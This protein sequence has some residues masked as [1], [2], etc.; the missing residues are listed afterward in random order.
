MGVP[1]AATAPQASAATAPLVR[2][3][4]WTLPSGDQTVQEYA[5]AVAIMQARPAHDPTSWT[6]Q[7]AMHGTHARSVQPLFNGCQHGTWFF[8][9]WHR[10]FIYYFEQI[11]RAAVV[12]AG[13]AAD[14]SLPFW[15][16]GAGGQQ[17]TLPAAFRSPTLNGGPNPLF[18][19]ARAPGINRGL[20]LSPAVASATRALR[21]SR[22]VGISQFGGGVT[23]VAQ[24]S[25]STGQV[26]NQPHNV[27]HDAVGGNG[28][29]MADPDAAAADPI[30]WIHHAN[31]DRLWFIW[32]SPRHLGPNDP[33]WTGQAFSFFDAHGQRVTRT[34]ADV[35]DIVS[36]L[37]Y[38]YEVAPPARPA[39]GPR[40]TPEDVVTGP[41]PPE[42][43]PEL[44]GASETPVRLAGAPASVAL[45]ID[46]QAHEA[47]LAATGATA[48]QRILLGVED[49]EAE[50]N[51][52]T[53]YGIYLNL[54]ADASPDVAESHHAGNVSFFGVERARNPR[55]DEHAHSLRV[56]HDITELAQSLAAQ[57]EWDGRHVEVTFRPLGLIPQDQPELA[58]ALPDAVT[59]ADPP[60][61][62][63]RVSIFYE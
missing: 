43:E 59:D 25:N 60:V 54:P 23:G 11:V 57:G 9:A 34:P 17:A 29:L 61:T 16:Y 6:Y 56:V 15:D 55:G 7:A 4:I 28:G 13:G 39:G 26:E 10:M 5:Q 12:Q 48:P 3:N 51:P 20:A 38:T 40:P 44:V 2:R 62:I 33:R 31:I 8:V 37:G 49:I 41:E 45:Q 36:Q 46:P 53:V 52:G 1:S 63:G 27:I 58:H 47:A 18:E 32:S 30:F 42:G 22:F 14:W 21:A 35:V 19:S 50:Q 24:F